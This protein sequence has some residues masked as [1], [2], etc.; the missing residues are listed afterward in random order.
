M[1][2]ENQEME[3]RVERKNFDE[4]FVEKAQKSLL[5]SVVELESTKKELK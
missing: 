1:R 2:K 4:T 3:E 5:M